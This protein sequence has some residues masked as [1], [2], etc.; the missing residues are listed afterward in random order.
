M[1]TPS[2]AYIYVPL[3]GPIQLHVSNGGKWVRP[4]LTDNLNLRKLD[5][6][7]VNDALCWNIPRAKLQRLVTLIKETA[8]HAEVLRD[9]KPSK[10]KCDTRCTGAKG[11]NCACECNGEHHALGSASIPIYEGWAHVGESTLIENDKPLIR[12]L[13]RLETKVHETAAE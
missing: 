2:N 7:K 6:Q 5:N 8:S 4:W 1:T 12:V 9:Q 13:L 11:V 10:R 3:A